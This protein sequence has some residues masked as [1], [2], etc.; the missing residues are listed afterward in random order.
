M[1]AKPRQVTGLRAQPV[2]RYVAVAI[3]LTLWV[4]AAVCI[5]ELWLRNSSSNTWE[6]WIEPILTTIGEKTYQPWMLPGGIIISTLG[7]I[8]TWLALRPRTRTHHQVASAASIW[9]R[10]VDIARVLTF[11]TRSVPGVS[12]AHSRVNSKTATIFFQSRD[13]RVTLPQEIEKAAT[14]RLKELGL[15][16][17]IRVEQ[18]ASN[19]AQG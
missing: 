10:Q 9:L 11:T 5:R 8:V 19:R 14:A 3:G 13:S 7:V 12:T 18:Q 17:P 6:S 1:S 16:M 15:A 2:A 4:G